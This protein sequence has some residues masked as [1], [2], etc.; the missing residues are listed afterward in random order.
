MIESRDL[1]TDH[2]IQLEEALLTNWEA[3]QPRVLQTEMVRSGYL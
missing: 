3:F 1:S 2:N